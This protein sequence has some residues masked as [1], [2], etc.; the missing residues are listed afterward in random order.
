M[1]PSPG[2]QGE[3][4]D[5]WILDRHS[6]IFT[7]GVIPAKRHRTAWVNGVEGTDRGPFRRPYVGI[8]GCGEV[9][10]LMKILCLGG[11]F[12][13]RYL[14]SHF[15]D[16]CRVE[17]ASRAPRSLQD[18]GFL[19][20]QGATSEPPDLILDTVPAIHDDGTLRDHPYK[21]LLTTHLAAHPT[22]STIHLSSTS[23]YASDFVSATESE[24]PFLDET[25]PTRP[26]S[27]RGRLRLELE[28]LFLSIAPAASIIRCAGIYGPG[29][30]LA[31]RF[32]RGDFRKTDQGNRVVSRIHVHDLCR[33][34][35][36]LGLRSLELDE[37]ERPRLVHAVDE[38]PAPRAEVYSYLE[39]LLG[40]QIPGD[41]R[42]DRPRGRQIRSLFAKGLLGG[43]Y[44]FPSY[45]EGFPDCIGGGSRVES[46]KSKS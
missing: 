24:I 6:S 41:W 31:L 38:D 19:V 46:L 10:N 3:N 16:S 15:A 40:I 2:L 43:R 4:R 33:L 30:C 29:R 32:Q 20:T 39:E 1:P 13:G 11:S 35:L 25:A 9:K 22:T 5:Q 28:S 12:T 36:T 18:R 17:F 42:T 26:D 21:T 45:L 27:D 34:I 7:T 8:L 37:E 23:V 14:A 44:R